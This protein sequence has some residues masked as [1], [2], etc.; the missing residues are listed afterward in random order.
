MIKPTNGWKLELGN[1]TASPYTIELDAATKLPVAPETEQQKFY[2]TYFAG[3]EHQNFVGYDDEG[4]FVSVSLLKDETHYRAI[5]RSA[6]GEEKVSMPVGLVKT[7]T[8]SSSSLFKTTPKQILKAMFPQIKFK[9]LKVVK[10]E[11]HVSDLKLFESNENH[12]SFKW[13]VL[14]CGKGQ[15]DENSM[16]QVR[17]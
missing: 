7:S 2:A 12:I 6:T 1:A 9:Q 15:T 3:K 5:V 11:K 4:K 16:F 14:Y 8:S 13:G 10:D 17:L